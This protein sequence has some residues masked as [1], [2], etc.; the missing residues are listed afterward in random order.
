MYSFLDLAQLSQA[1]ANNSKGALQSG[2]SS[3]GHCL[4][5]TASD[6]VSGIAG[7]LTGKIISHTVNHHRTSQNGVYKETFVI[8]YLIRI[9]LIAQKGRKI[10]CVPGMRHAGRIVVVSGLIKR[11]GAVSVFVN[12]HAV[13]ITGSLHMDIGKSENL[14]F[15]KD[16]SIGSSIKFYGTCKLRLRS[17]S[18]DPCNSGRSGM[19]QKILKMR[20]GSRLIHECTS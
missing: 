3:V 13:E 2:L 20:S 4:N 5:D 9:T 11:S 6:L 7:R 10:P 16:S 12:V 18:L 14:G 8:K 1:S 17:V 19:G 15:H